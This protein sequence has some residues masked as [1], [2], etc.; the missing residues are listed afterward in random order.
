MNIFKRAA[1]KYKQK[2]NKDND[3]PKMTKGEERH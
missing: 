1:D 3:K 2:Y